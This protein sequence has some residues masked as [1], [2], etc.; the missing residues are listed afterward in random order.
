VPPSYYSFDYRS[1]RLIIKR[2]RGFVGMLSGL[3]GVD[4]GQ[5]V[6]RDLAENYKKGR[7]CI[8][9]NNL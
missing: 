1:L 8:C 9:L 3:L 6:L 2:E 7:V 4:Y 5:N